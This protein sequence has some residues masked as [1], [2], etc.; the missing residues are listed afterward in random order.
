MITLSPPC[1]GHFAIK[2]G[3]S[4]HDSMSDKCNQIGKL[5]PGGWINIK[6]PSYQYRKYHCGDKTILWPSYLHNGIS[7]T[8]KTTPLYWIGA[9]EWV[10]APKILQWNSLK[11]SNLLIQENIF[12][13]VLWK[14]SDILFWPQCV[15]ESNRSQHAA[16]KLNVRFVILRTCGRKITDNEK[17]IN[18]AHRRPPEQSSGGGYWDDF[19]HSIICLQIQN[20]IWWLCLVPTSTTRFASDVGYRMAKNV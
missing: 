12:D 2:Y 11:N 13:N 20:K 17:S 8:G 3:K 10:H 6:M 16:E 9:L 4:V 19:L 18:Q 14:M 5:K 1:V 7:Y 15:N